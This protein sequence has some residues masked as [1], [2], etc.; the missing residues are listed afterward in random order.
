MSDKPAAPPSKRLKPDAPSE[1]GLGPDRH[2]DNRSF[3]DDASGAAP[4]GA[5]PT[6][7]TPG[8]RDHGRWASLAALTVS[9]GR[10]QA[11]PVMPA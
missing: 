9:A 5:S 4:V 8:R 3:L 11:L 6:R 1:A 10:P 2:I 7:K